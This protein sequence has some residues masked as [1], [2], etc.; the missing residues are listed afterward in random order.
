MTRSVFADMLDFT[1]DSRGA[2]LV[3]LVR[4]NTEVICSG[5]RFW[6]YSAPTLFPIVGRLKDDTFRFDG[7]SYSLQQHGFARNRDFMCIDDRPLTYRTAYDD[8]TL[9]LFPFK[10]ALTVSFR[11]LANELLITT[12]VHN[13]DEVTMWFSVGAHPALRLFEGGSLSD[14]CLA[15]EREETAAPIILKDGLFSKERRS[16]LVGRTLPL[17]YDLF[18]DDALIFDDLKSSTIELRRDNDRV[19]SGK[20]KVDSGQWTVDASSTFDLLIV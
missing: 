16:L 1:V 17:S 6:N 18:K 13:L 8:D 3:S 2:Q 9:K 12:R 11:P 14:Y 19:L 7:K 4:N 15:F 10:F 5:T 20:W